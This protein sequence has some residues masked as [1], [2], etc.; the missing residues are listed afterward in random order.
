MH[1]FPFSNK[2][3]KQNTNYSPMAVLDLDLYSYRCVNQR[4]WRTI[5]MF[6]EGMVR[7]RVNWQRTA[8]GY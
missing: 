2:I 3:R 1:K 8:K 7:A 5:W 6:R 4:E